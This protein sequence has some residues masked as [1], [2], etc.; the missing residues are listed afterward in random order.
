MANGP[1]QNIMTRRGDPLHVSDPDLPASFHSVM[2]MAPIH[3]PSVIS[4]MKPS[5]CSL[6]DDVAWGK[7]GSAKL[8]YILPDRNRSNVFKGQL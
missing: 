2:A 5:I 8:E 6:H 1:N 3:L 4:G 7:T